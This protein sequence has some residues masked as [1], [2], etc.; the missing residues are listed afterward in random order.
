MLTAHLPI[1]AYL[2]P[3]DGSVSYDV[4]KSGVKVAVLTFGKSAYRLGETVLGVVE[5]NER[6]ARSRVLKVRFHPFSPHNWAVVLILLYSSPRSSKLKKLSPLPSPPEPHAASTQSITPPSSHIPYEL[7]SRSIFHPTLRLT[8]GCI[9][10]TYH[11]TVPLH[12]TT[13][14][15]PGEDWSGKSGFVC[16]L[17]WRMK[18]RMGGTRG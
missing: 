5:L 16:L 10:I 4:N 1:L 9:R 18:E 6:L 17:V 3:I 12:R 14:R 8:L 11:C 13:K 7:R 15:G 2:L